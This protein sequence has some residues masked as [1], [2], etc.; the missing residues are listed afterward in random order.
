M[1]NKNIN[2]KEINKIITDSIKH[3][4]V[5][6][7]YALHTLNEGVDS[8]IDEISNTMN[9]KDIAH[10]IFYFIDKMREKGCE[11]SELDEIEQLVNKIK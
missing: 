5:L 9:T 2:F 8:E 3:K 4:K 11:M 10:K 6:G 1:I 7:N